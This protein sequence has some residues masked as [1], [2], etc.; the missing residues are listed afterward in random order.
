MLTTTKIEGVTHRWVAKEA[1]GR[2]GIF[3]I[4]D[5][6]LLLTLRGQGRIGFL[7][8]LNLAS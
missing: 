4:I 3:I 6:E 8:A 2:T 5:K 7:V 1:L